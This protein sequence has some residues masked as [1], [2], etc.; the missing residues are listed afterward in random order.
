VA[1]GQ[2]TV[3]A[4]S[5]ERV[6]LRRG[7]VLEGITL[8]WNVA[9]ILVLAVAA[10]AARSVAL[11][12]FGLDSLIEI[13]ASVV[14]LWELSGTG[15]DRERRA[16][17]L[18]GSAFVALAAYLTVQSAV[19]LAAGYRPGHSLLGIAWT[20][21]TA[22]AMFVLAAGKART[23]RALGNP[24][25]MTEGRVTL[26]DGILATAVLAGLALN[27]AAGWWWADPL[28]ALVIVFY[29]LREAR[30]IFWPGR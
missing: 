1:S 20:A 24:V 16:L 8:G 12:G 2:P 21:V 9:G 11:A 25:L 13:G 18:I 5:S 19:V 30:E 15:E 23:G 6:L 29:A 26:A 3:D 10:V 17:R 22:A 7:R 28:A 14:V 27:A 4:P